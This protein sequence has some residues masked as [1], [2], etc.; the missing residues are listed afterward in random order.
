MVKERS[1]RRS[2]EHA[3][4]ATVAAGSDDD[5]RSAARGIR[6]YLGR[7]SL[8]QPLFY[9]DV[10]VLLAKA[11]HGFGHR[12]QLVGVRLFE[13][14]GVWHHDAGGV[15]GRGVPDVQKSEPGVTQR[16]FFEGQVSGV[17]R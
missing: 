13:E 10:W 16:G 5:Q 12:T 11:S 6:K 17:H 7:A 14:Q 15:V 3:G 4:E 8:P 2:E 1:A 9:L